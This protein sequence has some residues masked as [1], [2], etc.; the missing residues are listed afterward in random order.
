MTTPMGRMLAHFLAAVA[1]FERELIREHV[2]S[3]LANA[4]AKG[5]SLGRPS[6]RLFTS[7][8]RSVAFGPGGNLSRSCS[9]DGLKCFDSRSGEAGKEKLQAD[10]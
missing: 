10:G 9:T 8:K 4:K 3:G 5:K 2:R 1:E 7:A 6:R